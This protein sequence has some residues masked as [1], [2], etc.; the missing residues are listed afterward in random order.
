MLPKLRSIYAK[1]DILLFVAILLIIILIRYNVEILDGSEFNML[2][3]NVENAS[4]VRD[5]EDTEGTE[6]TE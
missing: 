3:R 6:G 5:A 2:A 1:W 4:L